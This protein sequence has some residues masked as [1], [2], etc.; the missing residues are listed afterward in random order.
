[1]SGITPVEFLRFFVEQGHTF[2]IIFMEDGKVSE[3]TIEV[4]KDNI[5]EFAKRMEEKE[6]QSAED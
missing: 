4:N 2:E 3:E 1:M 6:L 5:E